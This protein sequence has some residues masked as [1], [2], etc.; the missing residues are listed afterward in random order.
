MLAG[1]QI[2]MA[3]VDFCG[4]IM[5]LDPGLPFVVGREGDLA[6]DD[7]P[8]LHRRFLV[9]DQRDGFWWL[10]NAGNRI[11]A[12]VSD[13]DGRMQAWL[14]PSAAMPLVFAHTVVLFNAG[15]TTY[16]FEISLDDAQFTPA[17]DPIPH[18]DGLT[19]GDVTF[20]PDQLIMIVALAEP[21]L[22]REG[23]GGTALPTTAEAA[24]RLGW[25]VTRFNRKL[26]NVCEKLSKIGIKGLH[27]GP[28]RLAVDR[29][30]R[31]V[32]Y[33]LAARWVTADHLKL[34]S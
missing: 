20:T 21:A 33:S 15:P 8:Y 19:M 11:S 34:L 23:W 17:H 2:V 24:R 9:L 5:P 3:H 27:G 26:D 1:R 32:E 7:N 10:H 16:E 6:F 25:S 29:R 14:A 28:D 22:R 31:L 18:S 13:L 4:E 12:T 30:A